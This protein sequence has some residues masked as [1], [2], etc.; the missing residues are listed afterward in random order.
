MCGSAT[1]A[2]VVSKACMMV[3]SMTD[4]VTKPRCALSG[5]A[6]VVAAVIVDLRA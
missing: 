1:L 4:T 3:A 2:I 5:F 6:A